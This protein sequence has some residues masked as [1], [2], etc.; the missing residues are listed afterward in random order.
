MWCEM[1]VLKLSGI[2]KDLIHSLEYGYNSVWVQFHVYHDFYKLSDCSGFTI[3]I[4]I[5]I[6]LSTLQEQKLSHLTSLLNFL[7]KFCTFISILK[8]E[9]DKE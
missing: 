9:E 2:Q 3:V 4:H 7:D 6:A 1:F 5:V 8:S